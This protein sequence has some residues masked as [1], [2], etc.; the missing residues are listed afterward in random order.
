MT[1]GTVVLGIGNTLL[2]DEGVGVHAV[3]QL[4]RSRP[5]LAGVRFLDGGTLSFTL[6]VPLA[7]AGHLIVVDAAELH[8]PAGTVRVFEDAAMDEYL[9]S[10][11]RRSVHEVG[12]VDLMAIARLSGRLPARRALIGV[13]PESVDW[14]E[15]PSA[16]V[17]AALPEV[18]ARARA[19]IA[20]WSQ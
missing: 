17:A 1:S 10:G 4:E 12:L 3:Q 5:S 20:R 6:A 18:C 8:A 9:N 16:A 14:G 13:Q 11:K 15:Q 19:L 2:R 7:E